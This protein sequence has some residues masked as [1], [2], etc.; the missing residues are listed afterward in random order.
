MTNWYERTSNHKHRV[1]WKKDAFLDKIARVL[2][3][4][5]MKHFPGTTDYLKA[6]FSAQSAGVSTEAVMRWESFPAAA[7]EGQT[8]AAAAGEEHT[9]VAVVEE[10]EF[11]F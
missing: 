3:K 10:H 11:F 2:H 9:S 1:Y 8:Q 6:T 5:F 7:S 4:I